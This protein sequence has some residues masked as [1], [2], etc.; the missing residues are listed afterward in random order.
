MLDEL[1]TAIDEVRVQVHSWDMEL[2]S[3]LDQLQ[4]TLD[5]MEPM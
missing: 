2:N 5:F 3:K 1:H 4:T